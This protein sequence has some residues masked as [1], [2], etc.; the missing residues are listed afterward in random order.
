MNGALGMVRRGITFT[1]AHLLS[2]EKGNFFDIFIC[3]FSSVTY[4]QIYFLVKTEI[5]EDNMNYLIHVLP[6]TD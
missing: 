3:F 5:D 6:N 1:Y 4:Q 2:S